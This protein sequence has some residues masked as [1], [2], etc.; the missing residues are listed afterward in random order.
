MPRHHI[1]QPTQALVIPHIAPPRQNPIH[2]LLLLACIVRELVERESWGRERGGRD[3]T[4]GG[5]EELMAGS[6]SGVGE[7]RG[8]VQGLGRGADEVE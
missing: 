5:V 4:E 7:G 2:L 6:G 1:L 3:R 8:G